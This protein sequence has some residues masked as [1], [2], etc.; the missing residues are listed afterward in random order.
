MSVLMLF[1]IPVFAATYKNLKAELPAIT[2]VLIA[3]SEFSRNYWWLAFS[4][5][6]GI[7]QAHER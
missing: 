7:T 3:I 6:R 4:W 2:Q 5:G 1:V